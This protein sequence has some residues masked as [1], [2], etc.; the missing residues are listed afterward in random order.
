MNCARTVHAPVR[1]EACVVHGVQAVPTIVCGLL[2][3]VL[4]RGQ[5]CAH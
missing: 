1:L 5:I 2:R 3:V 4:V